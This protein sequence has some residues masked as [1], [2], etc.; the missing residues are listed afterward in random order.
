MV[1]HFNVLLQPQLPRSIWFWRQSIS[2]SSFF[3]FHTLEQNSIHFGVPNE[4]VEIHWNWLPSE[5]EFWDQCRKKIW[6]TFLKLKKL[7]LSYSYWLVKSK[8]FKYCSILANWLILVRRIRPPKAAENPV[9][10][11]VRFSEYPAPYI[12][13]RM[14]SRRRATR[15][16]DDS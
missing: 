8:V 12:F 5:L 2:M 1:V 13:F 11:A 15:Y 16:D 6:T 9:L 4:I 7:Q 14:G 10:V 3:S